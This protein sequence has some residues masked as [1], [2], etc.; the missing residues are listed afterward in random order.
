MD[1]S[2]LFALNHHP[3]A[4]SHQLRP[5]QLA[6]LHVLLVMCSHVNKSSELSL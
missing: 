4:V 2:F 6:L 1:G 5:L 3:R